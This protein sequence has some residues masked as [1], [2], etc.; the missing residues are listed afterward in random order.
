MLLCNFLFCE[1]CFLELKL[2]LSPV[3]HRGREIG[4]AMCYRCLSYGAAALFPL[5]YT[6]DWVTYIY[7][8]VEL[9]LFCYVMLR[10]IMRIGK[11]HMLTHYMSKPFARKILSDWVFSS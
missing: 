1:S 3:I 8:T 2:T 5:Q 11:D 4:R 10:T 7:L 6:P 9:F